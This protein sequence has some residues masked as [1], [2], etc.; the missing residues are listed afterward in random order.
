MVGGIMLQFYLM[1]VLFNAAAGLLLVFAKE[2]PQDAAAGLNFFETKNFRLILGV[3]TVFTGIMKLL[4]VVQGD[5]P[6]LG[7][8][9]PALTGIG[10]GI[11][12]L[13]GYYKVSSS[14]PLTL[15]AF[16][17]TVFGSGQKYLGI[18]CLAAALL[19]FV[20]PHVLFL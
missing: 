18:A 20:F 5:I 1:A 14:V 4:S 15:P 2:E 6:V 8:F 17:E 12:L 11:C 9:L 10:G 19:H 7:D 13:Y 16:F 3:L